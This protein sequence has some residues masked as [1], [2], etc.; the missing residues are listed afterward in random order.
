[1]A[2]ERK[3][4][5]VIL[6]A[7]GFCGKLAALYIVEKYA[8]SGLRWA[9]AGRSAAKLE[10]VKKELKDLP[11]IIVA[12]TGDEAALKAC[13]SQTKVLLTTAGP[14]AR[15]GTPVV[16]ACVEA[17]TDYCD[18][19]GETQWIQD[20]IGLYDDKA[21]SS[22]ARIVHMCGHD[23]VPWDLMTLMLAKKLKENGE[24][25]Q[26]VDMYDEIVS[27]FS[28]GTLETA[29]GMMFGT[30]AT[31]TPAVKLGYDPMIKA[32]DKASTSKT[33][34]ANVSCV[35]PGADGQPP[36]MM[37][38][39]AGVNGTAVRRS[40]ALLNYGTEVTYCEGWSQSNRCAAYCKMLGL[41]AFGCLMACPPTRACLLKCC[42]PKPGEGPSDVESGWLRVTGVAKGEKG[43]KASA[44]IRFERDPGT[45][46]TARMLV[47][48]GLVLALEKD[49][50]CDGGVYTPAACQGETLL[51]RLTAHSDVATF[52]YHDEAAAK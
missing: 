18:I 47:E 30:G 51:K 22:G 32:G 21:R 3:F 9:I 28:G 15:F 14:Y 44:S 43:G 31:A 4:D 7:T 33:K 6:G 52:R 34:I 26:R 25:L 45:N 2:A 35:T 12:D 38:F 1:M 13:V 37:F 17:G 48:S 23:S 5:I 41:G 10:Q 42:L 24:G 36:R 39:M 50:K 19:T 40:N 11:E 49:F 27:G 16:Q 8:S 20:M 29:M 46:A